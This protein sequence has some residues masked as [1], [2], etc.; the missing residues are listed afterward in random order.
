MLFCCKLDHK[1]Q[2]FLRPPSAAGKKK[3]K[4][5][6]KTPLIKF[7]IAQKVVFRPKPTPQPPNPPIFEYFI[8]LCPKVHNYYFY[9]ELAVLAGRTSA[10]HPLP[11]ASEIHFAPNGRS[12]WAHY[13]YVRADTP[14]CIYFHEVSSW[15][16]GDLILLP[17]LL[18]SQ[19]SSQKMRF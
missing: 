8:D 10:L 14:K 13:Y 12:E 3:E 17:N 7:L 1:P 6:P 19:K 18:S 5:P 15:I 2:N 11:S 16:R 9:I 4:P